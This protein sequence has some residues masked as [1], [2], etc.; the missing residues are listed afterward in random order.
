MASKGQVETC[1]KSPMLDSLWGAYGAPLA[2]SLTSAIQRLHVMVRRWHRPILCGLL[3][4]HAALLA[5]CALI[6]SPTPDEPAHVAAGLS[7]WEFGEFSLYR[8]NP[9]LVRMAATAPLLLTDIKTDWSHYGTDLTARYEHRVGDDLVDANGSSI[10]RYVTIARWACTPFSLLGAMVCCWWARL[11]FGRLAGLVAAA[12]WCFSPMILGHGSLLTPDVAGTALGLAA[13]YCFSRWLMTPSWRRVLLV[14]A[15]FGLAETAKSTWIILFPA[16]ALIWLMFRLGMPRGG[17]SSKQASAVVGGVGGAG[18]ITRSVMTTLEPA[19]RP[20]APQLAII[21][22]V[23]W[24]ILVAAYGGQGVGAPLRTVPF[25]SQLL[26]SV[27]CTLDDKGEFV[28]RPALA[29][30][31]IPVPRDYLVGL[32]QQYR[33]LEGPNRSYLRGQWNSEGWWYYYAYGLAVKEPLGALALAALSGLFWCGLV[34]RRET[35]RRLSRTRLQHMAVGWLMLVCP[36]T[37]FSL[38]SINTGMNHHLR[39]V[40]PVLPYM[41]LLAAGHVARPGRWLVLRIVISGV[42]LTWAIVSS[43]VVYPHSLSYFNELAGG[44]AGGIYHLSSSNIDWGQ[45]LLLLADWKRQHA[46]NERI[47]LGYLGRVNPAYAGIDF[48]AAP[49]GQRG[50]Q[51]PVMKPGWYAISVAY[52][53]GRGYRIQSPHGRWIHVPEMALA[54]FRQR[55][56][57]GRVGYSIYLYRVRPGESREVLPPG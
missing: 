25:K 8:V 13:C 26:T 27:F 44:P 7:H 12:L 53:Q 40:M 18:F 21:L 38:A 42:L 10:F 56:P 52:L 23:G 31:P 1:A 9:P 22:F 14:G 36:V 2:M 32:D 51:P 45:D 5:Y 34:A 29:S 37:V 57:D 50:Q 6:H 48:E 54:Y 35:A 30:V 20:T 19:R 11:L 55:K 43:L 33:D 47:Y 28:V 15:V 4:I 49:L 16:F 41:Y 3:V 24:A 39:Y 46:P 17:K